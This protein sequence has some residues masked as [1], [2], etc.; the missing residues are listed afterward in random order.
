MSVEPTG[1][2][3]P[4]TRYFLSYTGIGL[5]LKLTG[6]LQA[7]DLRNRN[8]WFEAHHDAQGRVQAI[9]KQVYGEVEMRHDYAYDTQGRLLSATVQT[10]DDEP[11]V[12]AFDPG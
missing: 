4:P 8:T 7:S 11:R 9:V 5:P 6:E 1:V 10:G 3:T 2:D 12:I